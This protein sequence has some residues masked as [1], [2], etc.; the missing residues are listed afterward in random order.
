M[1]H[2]RIHIIKMF[3]EEAEMSFPAMVCR[4]RLAKSFDRCLAD[5]RMC[6]AAF[7]GGTG[8]LDS[9]VGPLKNGL[10]FIMVFG[11][12]AGCVMVMSGFSTRNETK[13]G[14]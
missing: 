10:N 12:I 6:E 9:F 11:F 14:K 5:L 8:S 3:R 13:I 7:A 4:Q 2:G 1:L